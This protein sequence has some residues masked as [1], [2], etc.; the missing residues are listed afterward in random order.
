M[1]AS[2]EQ[3]V[4]TEYE[5]ILLRERVV[6]GITPAETSQLLND[7]CTLAERCHPSGQWQPLLPDPDDEAFAILASE[8]NADSLVTHNRQ[9]YGPARQL[10]IQVVTPKEFLDKVR[11]G[12]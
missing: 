5:E 3:P 4:V 7:F 6:L 1:D 12:L 2:S 9:H 8:A 11:A 10:G